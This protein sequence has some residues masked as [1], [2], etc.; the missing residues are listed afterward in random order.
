VTRLLIAAYLVEAG[1]VLTFAPWTGFWE[2]NYL[3][4][5]SPWL[6]TLMFNAYV[7]GAITGVG[8][9]TMVAG[10]R[11][12]AVAVAGRPHASASPPAGGETP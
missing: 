7:K 3:A 1:L 4:Q 10:L 9:I 12:G 2:R 11:D 8:L 5:A 6:G